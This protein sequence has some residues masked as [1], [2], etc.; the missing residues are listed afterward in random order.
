VGRLVAERQPWLYIPAFA[1]IAE[2]LGGDVQFVIGGDG[3]EEP[4]LRRLV[5]EHGLEGRV[6]FIGLVRDMEQFLPLLDLYISL[7]VG[8]VPGVA[9][10]QAVAAGVPVI[11]VQIQPEYQGSEDWIWSG[12]EPA[13]VGDKAIELLRSQRSLD[14]LRA[15]QR[16]H[17]D[18]SHSASA[19]ASDYERLYRDASAHRSNRNRV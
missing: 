11:A 6:H 10:L 12:S 14:Q 7:N 1:R 17:L 18:A 16:A 5:S 9:G 19:M 3:E 4:A 15:A 8:P 2:E 13:N